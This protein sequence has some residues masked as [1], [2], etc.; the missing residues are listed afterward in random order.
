MVAMTILGAFLQRV[1][2]YLAIIRS[3]KH[4]A[5]EPPP[6]EGRRAG[7]KDEGKNR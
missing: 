5:S 4:A 1:K 6:E 3:G 7:E 2:T